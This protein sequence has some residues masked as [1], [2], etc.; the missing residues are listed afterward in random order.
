M[1]LCKLQNRER[2]RGKRWY[3]LLCA[4][5]EREVGRKEKKKK[6]KKKEKKKKK[7]KRKKKKKEQIK[8]SKD[9]TPDYPR[10]GLCM[11]SK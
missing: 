3:V 1:I 9:Q 6:E 10:P 11:I 5:V 2:H 4:R 8:G 7:K